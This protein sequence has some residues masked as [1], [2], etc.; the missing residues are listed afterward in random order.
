MQQC[1]IEG[2]EHHRICRK[3]HKCCCT[4]S[5]NQLASQKGPRSVRVAGGGGQADRTSPRILQ[6]ASQSRKPSPPGRIIPHIFWSLVSPKSVSASGHFHP[7]ILVLPD[8]WRCHFPKLHQV[9]C[10]TAHWHFL[11]SL[12]HFFSCY[13]LA[14]KSTLSVQCLT[15]RE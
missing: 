4:A 9:P 12:L 10:P 5:N 3:K 1:S 7:L 8:A 2:L 14:L 15:T 11:V 13:L 6:A